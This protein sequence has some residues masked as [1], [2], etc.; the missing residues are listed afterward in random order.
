MND[1]IFLIEGNADVLKIKNDLSRYHNSKVFALDYDAHNLLTENNIKHEI[2]E[3]YLT[4]EDRRRIDDDSIHTTISWYDNHAIKEL[5]TF[6]GINLGSLIEMELL[7]YFVKIYGHT[8]MIDKII[9]KE[10]PVQVISYTSTNDYV[11]R[12]CK[13]KNIQVTSHTLSQL[14]S[15]HFD[16]LNIKYNLGS[17]P[18]SITISRKTFMQIRKIVDK[19]T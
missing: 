2:A 16:K 14:S 5:L 13:Q 3:N 7:L 18:I 12:I 19:T 6:E 15:L 8:I 11:E 10:L 17:Y 4:I 1:T 9:A